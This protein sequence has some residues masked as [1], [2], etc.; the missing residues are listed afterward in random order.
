VA[1]AYGVWRR[2]RCTGAS[3]WASSAP[4][5]SSTATGAIARVFEKVKPAGHAEA[6]AAAVA[7]LG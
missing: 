3:T 2:S 4:R 7:E 1:E 6:V 5:S